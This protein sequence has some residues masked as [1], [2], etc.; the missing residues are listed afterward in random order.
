MKFIFLLSGILLFSFYNAA[1]QPAFNDNGKTMDI[2]KKVYNCE[3][4]EYENW[5]EDD[6][7]DSC[8]TVCLVNSDKVPSKSNLEELVNQ[9]K[10]IA[11]SVKSALVTPED[12]NSFYIIFVKKEI[13]FGNITR[14]H[15]AGGVIPGAEL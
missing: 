4:I 13:V 5:T 7:T 1:A 12:Y 10:H 6:A 14:S 3:A 15:S 8:L 11:L 9:L 2:L